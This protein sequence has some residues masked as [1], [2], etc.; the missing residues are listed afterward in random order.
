MVLNTTWLY[1]YGIYYLFIYLSI[2]LLLCSVVLLNIT[3]ELLDKKKIFGGS[4]R[5]SHLKSKNLTSLL[6][7]H[8]HFS[9]SL[10]WPLW[11]QAFSPS[12]VNMSSQDQIFWPYFLLFTFVQWLPYLS[13]CPNPKTCTLLSLM[14]CWSCPVVPSPIADPF[15][16]YLVR[17][18]W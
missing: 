10:I 9:D 18:K 6:N 15:I 7:P 5:G 14:R 1:A 4:L 11:F 12:T 13:H 2:Y 8:G 3:W 16:A 17:S